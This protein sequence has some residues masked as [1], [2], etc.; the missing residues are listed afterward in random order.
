MLAIDYLISCQKIKS[1][2]V[3]FGGADCI[4]YGAAYRDSDAFFCHPPC[5]R[6]LQGLF[7]SILVSFCQFFVIL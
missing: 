5:G 3:D 6:N 4:I 1:P 2:V 7:L